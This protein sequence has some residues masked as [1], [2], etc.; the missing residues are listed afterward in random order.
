MAN[1]TRGGETNVL[2]PK[3]TLKFLTE[4]SDFQIT[5]KPDNNQVDQDVLDSLKQGRAMEESVISLATKNAMEDDSAIFSFVIVGD[6]YWDRLLNT[7]DAVIL[8]VHPG[9][10]SD[11]QYNP[12]L[13]SG[14]IS[15]IRLEGDYGANAKMYRITGHSMVKALLSYDIGVIQ[16][17]SIGLTEIGWIVDEDDGKGGIP[18]TGKTAI[19]VI[20][21]IL[22]RFVRETATEDN[23]D[24]KHAYMEYNF[25]NGKGITNYLVWNINPKH[26]NSWGPEFEFLLSPDR[27]INFDGSIKE[28]LDVATGR[29][30]NE[31][32]VESTPTG[33][34]ELIVRK[35]PFNPEDWQELPIHKITSND[36]IKESVGKTDMEAYAI[37]HVKMATKLGNLDSIGMGAFPRYYP[38]LVKKYGYRALEIDSIYLS[39]FTNLDE[40]ENQFDLSGSSGSSDSGGGGDDASG[41]QAVGGDNPEK[42]WN[43]FRSAGFSEASTAG[44]LANSEHESGINPKKRQYPNGPAMGAFQWEGA[45]NEDGANPYGRFANLVNYAKQKGKKWYDLQVQ[46]DFLVYEMNGG[47]PTT[48]YLLGQHCGGMSGFKKLTDPGRSAD[49][50]MWCF[51]RPKVQ[52]PGLR[53]A[54]AN[55]WYNKFKGKKV[56]KVTTLGTIEEI[57]YNLTPVGDPN[58]LLPG[59]YQH[60]QNVLMKYNNADFRL[61]GDKIAVE[62]ESKTCLTSY[63]A[64]STVDSLKTML[65]YD[66]S[67][68]IDAVRDAVS[69]SLISTTQF[70]K[71]ESKNPDKRKASYQEIDKDAKVVIS[72]NRGKSDKDKKEAWDG[73][74][75]NLLKT[76]SDL[77]KLQASNIRAGYEK[78]GKLSRES[79]EE[80][81]KDKGS[82]SDGESAN[83]G[84]PEQIKVINETLFNWY[85]D[86]PNFYSGEITVLGHPSYRIG[87][88]LSIEDYQNGDTWEYYI[89]SVQHEYSYGEGYKTVIGVTR[90]LPHGG[91]YRFSNLWG[92]SLEFKGGLIG[93]PSIQELNELSKKEIQEAQNGG[94]GKGSSSSDDEGSSSDRPSAGG[95]GSNVAEKAVDFAL[96]HEKGKTKW[97][98]YY[99]W[100]GGRDRNM[101][102][103]E[104]PIHGDC[105]SFIFEVYNQNGYEFSCKRGSATTWSIKADKG[106]KT[107]FTRGQKSK[108]MLD[109]MKRGD[110]IWFGADDYHIG[111]YIGN[112]R[113]IG[114]QGTP[115]IDYNGGIKTEDLLSSYWWSTFNGDV[116]RL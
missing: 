109:K 59:D 90:G 65:Y 46:C 115:T 91:K 64:K 47:D 67:Q 84:G 96:K 75:S 73:F 37:F 101:F 32:F 11:S 48:K 55:K 51:E 5:Y 10:N 68:V 26:W 40:V 114:L 92:K 52:T 16:D 22:K 21:S 88:R 104:N 54:S 8:S 82:D 23:K 43:Y 50:F 44:I 87:E 78:D 17:V 41:G 69:K 60:V 83:T 57:D 72:S 36:V 20:E 93:E 13:L 6:T 24:G 108:S 77:T 56:K 42:M 86:N 89:E 112:G 35:T 107:V 76:Y 18:F 3:F 7:N 95:K 34:S 15:D 116:K 9:G 66:N 4:H 53:T 1:V 39:G 58:K 105:S 25:A 80:I 103:G 38:G 111:M 98:S 33:E 2:R 102:N 29:P 74:Q 81:I 19:Q 71:T 63:Q 79:Y 28:M 31:L 49:V 12:V 61:N 85:A 97:K 106:L 70:K 113:F 62:L 14:L 100:G 30:F 27:F 110:L 94:G 99:D 45:S